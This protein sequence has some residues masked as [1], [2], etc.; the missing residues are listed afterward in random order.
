MLAWSDETGDA[1]KLP[2]RSIKA[3]LYKEPPTPLSPKENFDSLKL[4]SL[5][6]STP[7][8]PPQPLP[9]PP[10]PALKY[11][12]NICI[13]TKFTFKDITNHK[14]LVCELVERF[15][16]P[17]EMDVESWLVRLAFMTPEMDNQHI[18]P[19]KRL[20]TS[21]INKQIIEL[22]QTYLTK[23]GKKPFSCVDI[24]LVE[25]GQLNIS[26]Q[27]PQQTLV[28]EKA[29]ATA[30]AASASASA[31]ES[32][33]ASTNSLPNSLP[34]SSGQ[35]NSFT[36]TSQCHQKFDIDK[37]DLNR[38]GLAKVATLLQQEG[39]F[40]LRPELPHQVQILLDSQLSSHIGQCLRDA[41]SY[42]ALRKM[43]CKMDKCYARL[44]KASTGQPDYEWVRGC[45][46]EIDVDREK[47]TVRNLD[48]GSHKEVY[49]SDVFPYM[50][51]DPS[52]SVLDPAF[53]KPLALR[54]CL[55]DQRIFNVRNSM[56]EIINNASGNLVWFRLAEMVTFDNGS[57][58][59]WLALV[60]TH[61]GNL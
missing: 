53:A 14:R 12:S 10:P 40:W 39:V 2:F 31:E 60:F 59:Y 43:P 26:E 35:N 23:G 58:N 37:T 52:E 27:Q 28:A 41:K 13:N 30:A 61:K 34:N 15:Y 18:N 6:A 49:L 24:R 17:T 36:F 9:S 55:F 21:S 32:A 48:R 56:R 54:C 38:T 3:Y 45:V 11:E 7:L 4:N 29:I 46:E 16:D 5:E 44:R 50:P 8:S 22:N 51:L 33:E 20:H 19:K 47:C 42:S 57:G 25:N 1:V